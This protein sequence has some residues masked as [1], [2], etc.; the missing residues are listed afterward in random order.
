MT[1]M[2][3]D[4]V[5][6][7]RLEAGQPLVLQRA[8]TDLVALVRATV[9][10]QQAMTQQHMLLVSVSDPELVGE[11]DAARLRRALENLLSN[12]IKYSPR[13][14]EVRVEVATD[15]TAGARR[16]VVRVADQGLGI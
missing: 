5:D 13:G 6:A 7:A 16:A 11:W 2:M 15:T 10:E 12:A 14:G 3:E 9:A 8:S 4:L 1:R